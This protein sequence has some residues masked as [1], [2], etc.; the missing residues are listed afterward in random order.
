MQIDAAT[1]FRFPASVKIVKF[2]ICC[3]QA[4]PQLRINEKHKLLIQICAILTKIDDNMTK[5]K[6]IMIWGSLKCKR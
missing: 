1:A 5:R 4:K 6:W 3:S 2:L